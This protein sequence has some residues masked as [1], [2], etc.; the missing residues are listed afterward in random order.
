MGD[1]GGHIERCTGYSGTTRV[2]LGFVGSGF[3]G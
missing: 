3:R 2:G 1:M